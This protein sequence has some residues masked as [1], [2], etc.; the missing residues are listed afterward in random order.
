METRATVK[1]Q[2]GM[3]EIES[4]TVFVHSAFSEK[5]QYGNLD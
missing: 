3:K 4:E 1:L 5:I 2:F